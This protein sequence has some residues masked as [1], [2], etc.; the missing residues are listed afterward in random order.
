[1]NFGQLS[2]NLWKR[3]LRRPDLN[4]D[5]ELLSLAI[6]AGHQQ[7][8]MDGDFR[9]ME[10]HAIISY[11]ANNIEGVAVGSTINTPSVSN[12]KRARAVWTVDG[13]NNRQSPI[14]P[15]TEDEIKNIKLTAKVTR[16][17][18]TLPTTNY[19]QRWFEREQVICLMIPPTGTTS[20]MVDFLQFLPD[21]VNPSD[22]DYFSN[23]YWLCLLYAAAWMGSI[24]VF[25]DKRADD[26]Q[27][28]YSTLLG[29]AIATDKGIK[30]GGMATAMP[31]VQPSTAPA[32]A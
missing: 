5:P 3:I 23:Y 31:L 13:S 6:N 9:C 1:M 30:Q 4:S 19:F 17:I 15:A 14:I 7:L 32:A 22:S 24:S 25:E 12:Y 26:F 11:P 2:E 8:Q 10:T 21:Y 28:T 18:D 20:L 29:Q 16:G 27:K